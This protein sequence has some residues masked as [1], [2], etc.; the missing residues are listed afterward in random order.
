LPIRYRAATVLLALATIPL[1]V[2]VNG[3]AQLITLVVIIA[4]LL[5]VEARTTP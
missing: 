5:A 1:G 2:Y 4:A 3:V